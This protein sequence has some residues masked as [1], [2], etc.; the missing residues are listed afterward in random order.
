ME[1]ASH[2]AKLT[3]ENSVATGSIGSGGSKLLP[4]SSQWPSERAASIKHA[5]LDATSYRA[6]LLIRGPVS[7]GNDDRTWGGQ[8]GLNPSTKQICIRLGPVGQIWEWRVEK[9]NM[10]LG[11]LRRRDDGRPLGVWRRIKNVQQDGDPAWQLLA[12]VAHSLAGQSAAGQG[13]DRAG[14]DVTSC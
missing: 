14:S 11:T 3:C 4:K 12:E 10:D 2:A 1:R 5:V 8:H 6:S 9:T 13:R 7:V